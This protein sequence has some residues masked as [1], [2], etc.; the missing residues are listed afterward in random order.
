[1]TEEE[2]RAAVL[3]ALVD[4]ES[5][6]KERRFRQVKTT[7]K[8]TVLATVLGS[9]GI[10]AANQDKASQPAANRVQQ[11]SAQP[12]DRAK[13][14]GR[15]V[16]RQ[17]IPG[18]AHF[19]LNEHQLTEANKTRLKAL[20]RQLPSSAVV[21]IV[22]RA[23]SVG[24]HAYNKNLSEKRASSVK[25]YLSSL[26]I[27]VKNVSG[28]VSDYNPDSWLLRRADLVVEHAEAAQVAIN[29]PPVLDLY[30]A[31]IA[32][33]QVKAED[34]VNP[35]MMMDP[36]RD[37]HASMRPQQANTYPPNMLVATEEQ[38]VS[39]SSTMTQKTA[40]NESP[41]K[42]SAKA[43]RVKGVAHFAL[44][45]AELTA[46]HKDRLDSFRHQLPRHVVL[47]VIGRTDATGEPAHN[48]SLGKQ[49]ALAVARYLASKGIK[50]ASTGV[51][52]ANARDD[53]WEARR[54][55]ILINHKA[56]GT[57]KSIKLPPLAQR[58][59]KTQT[60][61]PVEK[62]ASA[63]AQTSKSADKTAQALDPVKFKASLPPGYD[64]PYW[65][66]E[67]TK[68]SSTQLDKTSWSGKASG[69]SRRF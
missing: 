2:I 62:P 15:S 58:K 25:R 17:F 11:T 54:V 33:S 1:M 42:V 5:F 52:I 53:G 7:F 16:Q 32:V 35:D 40:Q 57:R 37:L 50:V 47:T 6:K 51:K 69:S 45:Q 28:E 43:H 46:A 4:Y 39:Q 66:D 60:E 18:A 21:N 34:K 68:A 8:G 65:W 19:G 14:S 24:G 10:M 26:G 48:Q 64:N 67:Q 61:A 63:P 13:Q 55:D 31:P 23:D 9:S 3:A 30:A 36:G 22:G 49:R 27:K 44:N 20:A 12:L 41:L 59:A 38:K 56:A 29:L